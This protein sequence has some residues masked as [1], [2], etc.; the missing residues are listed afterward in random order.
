MSVRNHS[1]MTPL[2]DSGDLIL[3]YAGADA[4]YVFGGLTGSIE[5]YS[6]GGDSAISYQSLISTL[7]P[8]AHYLDGGAGDDLVFGSGRDDVLE[9]GAAMTNCWGVTAATCSW[10]QR[11]EPPGRRCRQRYVPGAEQPRV[12]RQS[13]GAT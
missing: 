2:G 1:K 13:S 12:G 4:L 9:G 11:D 7:V 8:D 6:F 5:S 3:R 10:R